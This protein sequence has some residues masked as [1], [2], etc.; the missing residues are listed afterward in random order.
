MGVCLL[1]HSAHLLPDVY[2]V[3]CGLWEFAGEQVC[4]YVVMGRPRLER[5][6]RM[7]EWMAWVA[8]E[9]FCM[10]SVWR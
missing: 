2:S 5:F 9:W 8:V 10:E 7:D 1:P 3:V 6:T 4:P